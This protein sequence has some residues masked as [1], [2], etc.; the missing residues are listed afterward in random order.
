MH[1][2]VQVNIDIPIFE[3]EINVDVVDKWLNMLEGF[4]FVHDFFTRVNFNFPPLKGPP[5]SMSWAS[6]K[7]HPHGIDS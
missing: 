4:P 5:P 2:K 6:G 3:G 7:P 1:F